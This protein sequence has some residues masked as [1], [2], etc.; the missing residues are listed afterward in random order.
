MSGSHERGEGGRPAGTTGG[1]EARDDEG[2]PRNTLSWSVGEGRGL[3]LAW[4]IPEKA[5]N[6]LGFAFEPLL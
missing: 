5:I 6:G 4:D 1:A 3:G 2:E